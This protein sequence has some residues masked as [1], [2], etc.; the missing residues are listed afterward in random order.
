MPRLPPLSVDDVYKRLLIRSLRWV[1]CKLRALADDSTQWHL[2]YWT[3]FKRKPLC[4]LDWFQTKH[5]E[6]M[7]ASGSFRGINGANQGHPF[8]FVALRRAN[9]LAWNRGN[10]RWC[11]YHEAL[12]LAHVNETLA[13]LQ[14][15]TH[16]FGWRALADQ[17]KQLT[18]SSH[19]NRRRAARLLQAFTEHVKYDSSF[20][21]DTVQTLYS[22]LLCCVKYNT[23]RNNKCC[24]FVCCCCSWFISLCMYFLQLLSR[25]R[26]YSSRV[27][28]FSP[29]TKKEK[30]ALMILAGN[31]RFWFGMCVWMFCAPAYSYVSWCM[32]YTH[33]SHTLPICPISSKLV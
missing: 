30:N 2:Y 26:T 32:C 3:K 4:L 1:H 7:S 27:Q 9:S 15:V 10:V 21:Y 18:L 14:R 5:L 11:E 19:Q 31:Q 13:W 6:N 17:S 12:L 16:S 25:L 33:R 28:C 20:I 24:G 8:G 22:T 29:S 23:C